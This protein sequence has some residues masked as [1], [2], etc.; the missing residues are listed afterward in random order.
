MSRAG[1]G[2][3][4][5]SFGFLLSFLQLGCYLLALLLV[6]ALIAYGLFSPHRRQRN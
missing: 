3:L 5:E 2:S 1:Y 6:V 4:V